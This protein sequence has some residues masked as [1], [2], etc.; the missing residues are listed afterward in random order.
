VTTRD[1]E[2]VR[3]IGRLRMANA[4]QVA[5]RFRLREYGPDGV[6]TEREIRA[7]E[8]PL[9]VTSL[10][11]P[12]FAVPLTGAS[13]QLEPTPARHRRLHFPDCAVI[14]AAAEGTDGARHGAPRIQNAILEADSAARR[15][16]ESLGYGAVRVFRELRIE[17]DAPPPAPE[18]PEGLRVVPFDP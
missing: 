16:L 5:E 6:R 4:A 15:L 9:G 17:L 7:E 13:G 11:R 3:W 1:K 14:G 18:W 10:A 8:T 12:R 2:I